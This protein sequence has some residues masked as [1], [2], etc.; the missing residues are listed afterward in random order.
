MKK[1]LFLGVVAILLLLTLPIGVF[2][3]QQGQDIRSKAAPATTLSFSPTTITNK[4]VGDTFDVVVNI[5][6]GANVIQRMYI[7][8]GYD[9]ELL[10]VVSPII[11]SAN[12]PNITASEIIELNEAAIGIGT[13]PTQPFNGTGN[14]ATFTFKVKSTSSTSS[15]ITATADTFAYSPGEGSIN[16]LIGSPTPVTVSFTGG[17]T[18]VPT[19]SPASN[20]TPTTVPNSTTTIVPSRTPTPKPGAVSIT[21]AEKDDLNTLTLTGTAVSGSQITIALADGTS[22][23]TS[24]SAQGT[25]QATF[26]DITVEEETITLSAYDP[27]T[28]TTQTI[29]QSI[30]FSTMATESE[31]LPVTGSIPLT[32]F[33]LLL[34]FGSISMGLLIYRYSYA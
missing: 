2:F 26:D 4:T 23:V 14:V 27:T 16:A 1:K 17:S 34:G 33:L 30:S 22:T 13:S 32:A 18:A 31:S 8:L 25:W 19:T 7:S 11:N 3:L 29:T 15:Q 12:F 21:S 9:G 24:A 5:N 6:T 10:E 28:T 20:T